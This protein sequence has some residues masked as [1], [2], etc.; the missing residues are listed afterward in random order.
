MSIDNKIIAHNPYLVKRS[1]T[2]ENPLGPPALRLQLTSTA[3]GAALLLFQPSS[4]V[5]VL[6]TRIRR[7]YR[8]FADAV[9]GHHPLPPI[10]Q[11]NRTVCKIDPGPPVPALSTIHKTIVGLTT[12]SYADRI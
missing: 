9:Q 8:Q 1:T 12:L 6:H 3:R 2:S 5:D 10:T 11:S 7:K 4:I